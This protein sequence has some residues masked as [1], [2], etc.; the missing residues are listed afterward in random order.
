MLWRRTGPQHPLDGHA[1]APG[2]L[3]CW[4]YLFMAGRLAVG[5]VFPLLCD[6]WRDVHLSFGTSEFGTAELIW[7][8]EEAEAGEQVL[9][10][11]SVW[12]PRCSPWRHQ[13]GCVLFGE[14]SQMEHHQNGLSLSN[15]LGAALLGWGGMK[16]VGMGLDVSTHCCMWV[17]LFVPSTVSVPKYV[18]LQVLPPAFLT[19]WHVAVTT[20]SLDYRCL[21][22]PHQ[23]SHLLAQ[24]KYLLTFEYWRWVTSRSSG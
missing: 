19:V 9:L 21:M 4:T 15:Q 3:S 18:K 17:Q 22:I 13:S 14:T 20:H 11:T 6:F 23:N 12:T 8:T 16:W 10:G 5:F 1:G 2:P 24:F 7:L